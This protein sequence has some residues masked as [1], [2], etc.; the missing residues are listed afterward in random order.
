MLGGP[1]HG[2]GLANGLSTRLCRTRSAWTAIRSAGRSLIGPSF[3]EHEELVQGIVPQIADRRRD[4]DPRREV[5]ESQSNGETI[6]SERIEPQAG[7]GNHRIAEHL[8]RRTCV[9]AMEDPGASEE[10]A[11]DCANHRSTGGRHDGAEMKQLNRADHDS[12]VDGRGKQGAGTV[13]NPLPD[14][15]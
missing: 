5:G 8:P 13:A 15:Q 6:L 2:G 12:E 14:N 1:L 9:R 10:K 4:D 11:G 3:S 7:S